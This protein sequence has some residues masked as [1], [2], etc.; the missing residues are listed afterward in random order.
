MKTFWNLQFGHLNKYGDT[1]SDDG[2]IDCNDD[3][4]DDDGDD[5]DDTW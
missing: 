3:G 4:D 2:V 5:D 1:G